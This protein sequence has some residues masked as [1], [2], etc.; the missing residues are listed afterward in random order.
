MCAPKWAHFTIHEAR[1]GVGK[2]FGLF[3]KVSN[4][5]PT[6]RVRGK[7]EMTFNSVLLILEWSRQAV[8]LG[9]GQMELLTWEA[10]ARGVRDV[11][12][13][14]P[15]VQ[16]RLGSSSHGRPELMPYRAMSASHRSFVRRHCSITR[17]FLCKHIQ[18]NV[19][20]LPILYK[21]R[22]PS[23]QRLQTEQ[24]SVQENSLWCNE[25]KLLNKSYS[26]FSSLPFFCPPSII[27][28][29]RK[30]F[31]F[32]FFFYR[33]G[34]LVLGTGKTFIPLAGSWR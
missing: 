33:E 34:Q 23:L 19:H 4:Y 1:K 25:Y 28:N 11:A 8:G 5:F 20:F 24:R 32:L 7:R 29:S 14:T 31:F 22:Q 9:N 18:M 10:R 17:L 12:S 16:Q 26:G 3:L 30:V 21:K 2:K 13:L 15:E 27:I 6:I